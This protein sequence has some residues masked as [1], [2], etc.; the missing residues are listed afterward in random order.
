MLF[1]PS[2]SKGVLPTNFHKFISVIYSNERFT[3]IYIFKKLA[4]SS[5]NTTIDAQSQRPNAIF[6]MTEMSQLMSAATLYFSWVVTP[7]RGLGGGGI[8]A[9]TQ[10]MKSQ[11]MQYNAKDFNKVQKRTHTSKHLHY[12]PH[13]QMNL[14]YKD[15]VRCLLYSHW[16]KVRLSV[17]LTWTKKT[18]SSHLWAVF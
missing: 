1:P 12:S 16:I 15:H 9:W 2:T 6:P 18:I 11:N 7:R 10:W 14:R 3:Y 4:L 17:A 8:N 5:V 13:W